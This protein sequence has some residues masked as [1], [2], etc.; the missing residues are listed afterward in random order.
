MRKLLCRPGFMIPLFVIQFVPLVIFPASSYSTTTQ[1]W[2]LPVLISVMALVATLQLLLRYRPVPWP[3]YI[4]NF[5]QG[6]NIIS[7][8]MLLMPHASVHVGSAIRL[9]VPYVVLTFVSMLLSAFFIWYF[10]LVEVRRAVAVRF[11]RAQTQAQAK[12]GS[13]A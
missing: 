9:N 10:E 4:L 12:D 1:E 8:L 3:W 7:R 5:A 11:G 6:T 2:W 13:P